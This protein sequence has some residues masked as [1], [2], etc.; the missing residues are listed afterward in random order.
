MSEYRWG[1]WYGTEE[2]TEMT[3]VEKILAK[4][5]EMVYDTWYLKNYSQSPT[6]REIVGKQGPND[7]VFLTGLRVV[8]D[9]CLDK[10]RKEM[11]SEPKSDK[12]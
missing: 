12:V 9:A 5:G 11:T 2:D 10:K 1:S 4:V 6:R 8:I 3:D 7:K